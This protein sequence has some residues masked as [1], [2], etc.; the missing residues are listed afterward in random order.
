MGAGGVG[1]VNVMSSRVVG[2]YVRGGRT[3]SYN[4]MKSCY[5]S[6]HLAYMMGDGL[7]VRIVVTREP[8]CFQP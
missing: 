1:D 6:K 8:C 2:K 5:L 4:V 7:Y 3:D